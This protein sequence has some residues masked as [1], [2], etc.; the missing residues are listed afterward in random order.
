MFIVA[1]VGGFF[2]NPDPEL[3][4]RWYQLGAFQPFFR[5]HAELT[6]KRREPWLFGE[7]H[8]SLIR[9]AIEKRY[10]LLP[11]IY[12]LFQES[13]INGN[14]IVRSMMQEYPENEATFG[15]DN[16]FMLGPC[17]V[18]KPVDGAGIEEV[19]TYL[20]NETKSWYDYDTFAVVS[21][22]PKTCFAMKKTPMDVIPVYIRGGSI[23]ARKDRLH[24]SSLAMKSDP[25]TLIV[26]LENGLAKGSLYVDDGHSFE[27]QQGNYLYVVYEFSNNALKSKRLH[28][29]NNPMK[30]DDSYNTRIERIVILG[31]ENL[32]KITSI[33]ASGSVEI[34]HFS[35]AGI[36][37]LK[38]PNFRV[39]EDWEI[40]I[41][42][43]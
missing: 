33:K 37:T 11:Y 7:P 4:V 40:S 36:L 12:T 18:V 31:L 26:A 20:P 6:T 32:G 29:Q 13:H 30:P 39:G 28:A 10:K 25:F 14:P 23:F 3:L 16:Q 34:Q 24:R 9:A 22:D 19:K 15:M 35:S 21:V 41:N 42:T 1:D 8:T 5:A 27:Y 17:L 43:Q 38:N 2:G